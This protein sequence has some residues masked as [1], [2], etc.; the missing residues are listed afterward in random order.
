MPSQSRAVRRQLQDLQR[1]RGVEARLVVGT[2]C[3]ARDG[4]PIAN[5]PRAE[6]LR[7]ALLI[8]DDLATISVRDG[9]TEKELGEMFSFAFL[10]PKLEV[11]PGNRT[12]G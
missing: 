9:M 10:P 8:G 2:E 4:I 11:V 6:Q 7:A 3:P 5:I 12:V 1:R